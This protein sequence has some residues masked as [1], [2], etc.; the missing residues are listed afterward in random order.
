VIEIADA[1]TLEIFKVGR[2][3]SMVASGSALRRTGFKRSIGA[4]TV[5]PHCHIRK[6]EEHKKRMVENTI[7]R[8]KVANNDVQ[9]CVLEDN[10]QSLKDIR[11]PIAALLDSRP[12]SHDV[13]YQDFQ[14]KIKNMSDL[15]NNFS[16]SSPDAPD[17]APKSVH[18]EVPARE[19]SSHDAAVLTLTSPLEVTLV[20]R[21]KQ[22]AKAGNMSGLNPSN[23]SNQIST[24][25]HVK[26]D[27]ATSK[28]PPDEQHPPTI[29]GGAGFP[30]WLPTD[31]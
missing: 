23:L 10:I 14:D 8:G 21:G 11:A 3:D 18:I 13:V 27:L 6:Q 25:P 4:T 22:Q 16:L 17:P 1:R 2:G 5:N 19:I 7:L 12:N 20:Q 30:V 31:H 26:I 15:F 28:L 29:K 24:H 9:I